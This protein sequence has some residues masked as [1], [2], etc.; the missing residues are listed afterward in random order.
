MA[1]PHA[2]IVILQSHLQVLYNIIT[3]TFVIIISLFLGLIWEVG[4]DVGNVNCG[5]GVGRG[6]GSIIILK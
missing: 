2:P 1:T 4:K 3:L 5:E 6:G